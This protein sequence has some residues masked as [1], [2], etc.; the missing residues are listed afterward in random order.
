M[1]N[2]VLQSGGFPIELLVLAA[3]SLISLAGVWMTFTKANQPGWA[4]L[5][6]FFNI[7]IMLK[8]GGNEWWWLLVLFVPIVQ[9]YAIYK[10]MSG[11]ARAF[12]QGIGFA[13][14]LWFLGFIFFP[15]LGFGNYTY[16]GKPS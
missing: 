8:I 1:V 9:L 12:G 7:Y 3:I 4:A 16:Q 14:G 2:T 13:L 15:L 10:I 11:V 6:P 5:I